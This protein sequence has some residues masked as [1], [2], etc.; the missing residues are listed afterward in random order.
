VENEEKRFPRGK[1]RTEILRWKRKKKPAK[2][3][4]DA[5]SLVDVPLYS[6]IDKGKIMPE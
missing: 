5:N 4:G 3:P 2:K 6:K 1:K